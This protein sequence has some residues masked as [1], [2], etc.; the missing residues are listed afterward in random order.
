MATHG[1]RPARSLRC[2]RS[3][4]GS[5]ADQDRIEWQIEWQ[6]VLT[7]ACPG[8]A[9]ARVRPCSAWSARLTSGC[10][11]ARWF[12]VRRRSTVR[13]RKGAPVHGKF[14]NMQLNTSPAASGTLSGRPSEAEAD[15]QACHRQRGGWSVSLPG[16]GP[17]S[18]GTSGN[19]VGGRLRGRGRI[20]ELSARR[21]V[22][23]GQGGSLS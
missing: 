4:C 12:M 19:Q 2:R 7:R 5:L 8:L 18:Q 6:I 20:R 21:G 1:G 15:Y 22:A 16:S 10:V 13:F 11:T 9:N 3:P 14:S 17:W 23:G